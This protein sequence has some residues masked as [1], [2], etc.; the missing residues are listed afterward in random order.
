M[1]W[2]E[3]EPG[4]Y[5]PDNKELK[6]LKKRN[7][8]KGSKDSQKKRRSHSPSRGKSFNYYENLEV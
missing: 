5:E 1:G 3:V 7:K 2:I 8:A 4:V 6:E